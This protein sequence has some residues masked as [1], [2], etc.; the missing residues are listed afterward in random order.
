MFEEIPEDRPGETSAAW[1]LQIN[2]PRPGRVSR[3]GSVCRVNAT[4]THCQVHSIISSS[5]GQSPSEVATHRSRHLPKR[6]AVW[7]FRVGEKLARWK[8]A[9]TDYPLDPRD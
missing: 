4:R 6:L 8:L 2:P 1:L 5:D 3:F 7:V 9:F